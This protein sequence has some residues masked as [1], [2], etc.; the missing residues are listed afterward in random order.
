MTTDYPCGADVAAQYASA[1]ACDLEAVLDGLR[2]HRDSRTAAG[3]EA[4]AAYI[5]ICEAILTGEGLRDA[6]VSFDEV[7][8]IASAP[9]YQRSREARF[10]VRELLRS[11]NFN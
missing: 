9:G 2:R 1:S 7:I 5:G 4:I 11:L 8:A 10:Q 6:I 3:R